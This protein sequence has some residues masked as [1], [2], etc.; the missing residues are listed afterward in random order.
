MK[1]GRSVATEIVGL[2]EK[3]NRIVG[4][5]SGGETQRL[6]LAQATVH[7]PDLLILDEPA[8]ALDPI[9]RIWYKTIPGRIGS[10]VTPAWRT[11]E[12]LQKEKTY[13]KKK[14]NQFLATVIWKRL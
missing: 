2:S 8:A 6:G 10:F 5:L 7:Y 13:R 12:I 1:K 3:D 4:K 11:L 14:T 9:G